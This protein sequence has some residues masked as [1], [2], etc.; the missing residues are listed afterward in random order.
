M[1]V[2]WGKIINGRPEWSPLGQINPVSGCVKISE[3]CK[4]CYACSDHT[5]HH[6]GGN[7]KGF[8]SRPFNEVIM[9]PKQL[10]K[11]D[12]L[13]RAKDPHVVFV[14]NMADLFQDAVPDTYIR[15]VIFEAAKCPK[16]TFLFLTKRA[17][18]MHDVVKDLDWERPGFVGHMLKHCWFG[19]TV[20][21]Q[22]RADER[23]PLLLQT[24]AAH[25]F[26]SCGPLLG[27]IDL[28]HMK[29]WQCEAGD[30]DPCC[31]G[32]VNVL[33]YKDGKGIDLII[34][35]GES[36]K[37]PSKARPAMPEWFCDLRDQCKAAG[38]AYYHKQD[39]D[40][41]PGWD[42]SKHPG[43]WDYVNDD[44]I[45]KQPFVGRNVA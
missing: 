30:K 7:G 38:V 20:E 15:K 17:Q 29:C 19:T 39:G 1:A 16:H 41:F 27:P 12:K 37:V 5:M 28:T 14:G 43:T 8:F 9:Q 22:Q 24:P 25:R 11:F 23:I 36:H 40:N 45:Y 35:E 21:N 26:L 13:S 10:E 32:H 4:N 42:N 2:Y 44:A 33:N 31:P 3:G 34:A 6:A 18:R